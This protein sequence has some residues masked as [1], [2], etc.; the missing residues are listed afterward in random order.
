MTIN[1][2]SVASTAD[3]VSE[4][5]SQAALDNLMKDPTEN[6]SAATK[7]RTAALAEVLSHLRNRT[8]P[9]LEADLSDVT[10]LAPVVVYGALARLYRNN[11]VVGDNEDVSANKYRIYQKLFESTLTGLRPTV[12]ALL[13]AGSATIQFS[14]R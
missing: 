14:R 7:A 3:L 1:V 2:D 9:V 4:L 11:I 8:P 12:Q 10:E 6:P 13:K 5:G